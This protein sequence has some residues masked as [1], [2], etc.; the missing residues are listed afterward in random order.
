MKPPRALEPMFDAAPNLNRVAE[1]DDRHDR[2]LLACADCGEHIL[3]DEFGDYCLAKEVVLRGRHVFRCCRCVERLGWTV[4][5]RAAAHRYAAWY[6]RE[7]K[8]EQLQRVRVR[9]GGRR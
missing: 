9:G 8:P 6:E 3:V 2:L 4:G 7:P 5:E 1:I